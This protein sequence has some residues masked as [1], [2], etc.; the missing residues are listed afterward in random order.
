MIYSF[1]INF[2]TNDGLDEY[3]ID[4]DIVLKNDFTDNTPFI[5]EERENK[6]WKNVEMGDSNA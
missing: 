3:F 2:Q 6:W 5:K 4:K 1:Q